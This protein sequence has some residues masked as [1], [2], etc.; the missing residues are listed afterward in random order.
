MKTQNASKSVKTSKKMRLS[1][2]NYTIKAN[3]ERN[4]SCSS[5]NRNQWC[6]RVF[7]NFDGVQHAIGQLDSDDDEDAA[8]T[9]WLCLRGV[10]HLGELKCHGGYVDQDATEFIWFV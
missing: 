3:R 10:M 1:N 6:A 9:D 4:V 5:Q 8:R 2:I 7:W